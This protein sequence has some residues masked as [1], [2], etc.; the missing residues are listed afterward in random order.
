MRRSA[1]SIPSNIAEG[2][3]KGDKELI[4]FLHIALGSLRLEHNI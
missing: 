1:V 2:A 3:P 4:H